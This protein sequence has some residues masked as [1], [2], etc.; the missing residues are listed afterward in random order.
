MSRCRNSKWKCVML[1][2]TV[3]VVWSIGTSTALCPQSSINSGL[4]A[5]DCIGSSKNRRLK[6]LVVFLLLLPSVGSILLPGARGDP[7]DLPHIYVELVEIYGFWK[8]ME[9]ENVITHVSQ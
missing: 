8:S 5:T 6:M 7:R 3:A 9:K 4:S 1:Y 2:Q